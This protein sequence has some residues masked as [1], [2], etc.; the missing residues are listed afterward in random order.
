[1]QSCQARRGFTSGCGEPGG[2]RVLRRH[3]CRTR[4]RRGRGR[5]RGR[6]HSASPAP[7]STATIARSRTGRAWACRAGRASVPWWRRP[8]SR[9]NLSNRSSTFF[10]VRTCA[11]VRARGC[12]AGSGS[13][14]TPIV[15]SPWTNSPLGACATVQVNNADRWAKWLFTV[16]AAITCTRPSARV[17][18]AVPAR[19]SRHPVTSRAVTAAIRSC[20]IS[21]PISP[22]TG[23]GAG[24]SCRPP[25]ANGPRARPQ[26]GRPRSR[27]RASPHPRPAPRGPPAPF[28]KR[29]RGDLHQRFPDDTVPAMR[30]SLHGRAIS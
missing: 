11:S 23:P 4:V 6:G 29:T 16:A 5:G 30:G 21:A 22:G 19:C 17:R 28:L 1:M 25:P 20:P 12:G 3:G 7:N 15:G 27:T 24:R 9:W 13:S 18:T 14:S 2:R 10:T 26:S 8:L